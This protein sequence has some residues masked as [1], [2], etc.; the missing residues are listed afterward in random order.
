MVA[1]ALT[2]HF[3][4]LWLLLLLISVA[5]YLLPNVGSFILSLVLF[6]F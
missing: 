5:C 3:I 1:G 6:S 2:I 4:V